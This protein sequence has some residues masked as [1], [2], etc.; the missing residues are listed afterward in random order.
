[1]CKI[2]EV[3][4]ALRFARNGLE[5][6]TGFNLTDDDRNDDSSADNDDNSR[7]LRDPKYDFKKSKQDP[8]EFDVKFHDD[9]DGKSWL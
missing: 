9:S 1:M 8:H 2:H 4:S 6:S 7:G 5:D 3:S